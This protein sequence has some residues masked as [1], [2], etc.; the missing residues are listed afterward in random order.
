PLVAI[1]S[2][3]DKGMKALMM[4]GV[5]K[6]LAAW[7]VRSR[8]SSEAVDLLSRMLQADPGKR[9]RVDEALELPLMSA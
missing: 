8:I 1:A 9:V 4:Y 5:E 2:P 6:I 7:G 3:A